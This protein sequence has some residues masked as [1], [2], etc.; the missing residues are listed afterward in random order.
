MDVKFFKSLFGLISIWL[1]IGC[2]DQ[3]FFGSNEKSGAVG[4]SGSNKVPAT[5]QTSQISD[6][7]K[8]G[9]KLGNDEELSQDRDDFESDPEDDENVVIETLGKVDGISSTKLKREIVFLVDGSDSTEPIRDNLSQNL[10]K[11][12]IEISNEIDAKIHIVGTWA[13]ENPNLPDSVAKYRYSIESRQMLDAAIDILSNDRLELRPDILV[14]VIV[15]TEDNDKMSASE[16]VKFLKKQKKRVHFHGIVGYESSQCGIVSPGYVYRDVDRKS[17][18]SGIMIDICSTHWQGILSKI[19][20][21]IKKLA[22][23]NFYKL[24]DAPSSASEIEV[25]LDGKILDKKLWEYDSDLR[26]LRIDP[27]LQGK[28]LKVRYAKDD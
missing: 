13:I 2:N 16:F 12:I 5:E 20:R 14:D 23:N 17:P 24:S 4:F 19:S 18:T 6:D 9:D 11:F 25:M 21:L 7:R 15:V 28:N 22:K 3:G 27:K 1:M 8:P 26:A 10:E